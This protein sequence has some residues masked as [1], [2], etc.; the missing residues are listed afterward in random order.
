MVFVSWSCQLDDGGA[1]AVVPGSVLPQVNDPR[2]IAECSN[3]HS[4]KVHGVG[5]PLLWYYFTRLTSHCSGMGST[6]RVTISMGGWGLYARAK[7]TCLCN[8]A[9]ILTV[10][11]SLRS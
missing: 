6:A 2:L 1:V 3:F 5:K 4:V 11:L 7:C 9:Y 10:M 8:D